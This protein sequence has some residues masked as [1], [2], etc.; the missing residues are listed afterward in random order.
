MKLLNLFKILLFTLLIAPLFA[1]P[2]VDDIYYRIR[3]DN[4]GY[5]EVYKSPLIVF[6]ER[7]RIE[8][9]TTGSPLANITE[10]P[11][12]SQIVVYFI[13]GENTG[14]ILSSVDDL[15]Y[16][17]E[18]E[19]GENQTVQ[20]P[21][22]FQMLINNKNE[23]VNLKNKL[24]ALFLNKR[25]EKVHQLKEIKHF[26]GNTK[27]LE[28]K[29]ILSPH[30]Y[31]INQSNWA[32]DVSVSRLSLKIFPWQ[33]LFGATDSA[34]S[35]FGIEYNKNEKV[36]N[37]LPYQNYAYNVGG[38][39]LFTTNEGDLT[40][41]MFFDLRGYYRGTYDVAS[42]YDDGLIIPSVI[43]PFYIGVFDEV[44]KLNSTN[45][46][47]ADIWVVKNPWYLNVYYSH[48]AKDFDD[49]YN[50]IKLN[51]TTS[52]AFYSLT[53]YQFTSSVF[54]EIT[55]SH[56]FSFNFGAGGYDVWQAFYLNDKNTYDERIYFKIL[57]LAELTYNFTAFPANNILGAGVKYFDGRF[58]A[59]AWLKLANDLILDGSELRAET[60]FISNRVITNGKDWDNTG[61]AIF[62][63][64]YRLGFSY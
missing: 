46:F 49:P 11:E 1:Q 33:G 39:F 17:V 37:I 62:Q 24:A 42:L 50:K 20:F 27:F 57:P 47:A 61:G 63:L 52:K 5:L 30:H 10:I 38:R 31:V 29:K 28:E 13:K 36:L 41:D 64:R 55:K 2:M 34:N 3:S 7:I 51:N 19:Y 40:R 4:T 18:I 9:Q 23:Y 22:L 43:P 58:K 21:K 16:V 32:L 60:H 56:Q 26:V 14:D 59:N 15:E 35:A 54:F 6:P 48:G 45:G 8:Y 12:N 44:A 25:I 53:Q